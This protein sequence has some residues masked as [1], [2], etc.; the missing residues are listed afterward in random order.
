MTQ[1]SSETPSPEKTPQ[2]DLEQL[3]E[4]YLKVKRLK[5]AVASNKLSFYRPHSKQ[6]DFHA[7]ERCDIRVVLG[8]NRSGK[9]TCG[10]T[11]A[12]AHALGERPWLPVDDPHRIV[13]LPSGDPVPVPN[14]GRIVAE[15][16]EINIVQTIHPKIMEWAP[17]GSITNIQ[18][19]PRG[20]PIRYD[21]S[22]G[23]VTY[24]MS[25]DQDAESFEGPNGH[26]FWLDEPSPQRIFN[27][28]RRGLV[29]FGGHCWMTLTPLSEPWINKVLVSKA[30]AADGRVWM[31][32]MRIWDNAISRGGHLPDKA[33]HS[34]LED[35]PPDERVAREE[36]KA[37]H[38]AGQVFP[39]WEA[40]APFWQPLPKDGMPR[41]WPRVCIIDPHPRK[42]IAVLWCAISP[43]NQLHAYRELYDPSLR[44]VAAVADRMHELEGWHFAGERRHW[45]KDKMVPIWR[46][47]AN[48]EPVGM[49]IID[50]SA[51]ENE[52]TSGE[53]VAEQF[54][55]YGFHTTDANKRNKDA[56]INA[57]HEA[58]R[59]KYEW[60]KPGLI[61]YHPCVTVRSNFENYV[62]ERWGSSR[63][64]GTKDEK[65][66]AVKADDD[67]IDCIRYVFQ[68]RLTYSL[69]RGLARSLE[70]ND[71]RRDSGP[72]QRAGKAGQEQWESA[73]RPELQSRTR[74][75]HGALG[76]VFGGRSGGQR[77]P[78]SRRHFRR[79]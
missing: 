73:V 8:G 32:R 71:G 33:I 35:L 23:S 34:F 38:L 59:L 52:K 14:I 24:L 60:S 44:T 70:E 6:R 43:D 67:F 61:V 68:M 28:L 30:N 62:Y 41:H 21:W 7:A 69:L 66:T 2:P 77:D 27:G 57:I 53:T 63:L 58:L 55:D 5:E 46:R 3:K 76:S 31:R 74:G 11:E 45:A 72:A 56:G 9:T 65:Q 1:D 50:T 18:K 13:H 22:N 49:Y 37:L 15:T 17:A 78:L 54:A 29:D 12:I 79:S 19:N 16:F 4:L 25:Y 20:V 10:A 64:Q 42:P 26:W 39:E 48:T 36:G 40:E 47:Q 75:L 51:N